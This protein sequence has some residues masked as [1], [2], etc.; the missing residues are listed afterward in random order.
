ML[1]GGV[2]EQAGFASGDE[3]IAIQ[4]LGNSNSA[5]RLQSLDDFTLYA[6]NAKKVT[7]TVARDKRLLALSLSLP[8]ASQ[9]VRLAVRDAALVDAWLAPQP[10]PQ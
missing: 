2:A 8:K 7:A 4:A 9:A 10:D 1:R 6:G 3:W 5:W